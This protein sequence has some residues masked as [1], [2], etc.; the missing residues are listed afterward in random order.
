MVE[1]KDSVMNVVTSAYNSNIQPIRPIK[2]KYKSIKISYQSEQLFLSV[3]IMG[4]QIFTKK[5]NGY[6]MYLI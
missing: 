1:V 5:T 3:F 6:S 4:I 2:V